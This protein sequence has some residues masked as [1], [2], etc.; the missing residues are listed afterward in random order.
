MRN[1]F[2]YF[3]GISKF[4]ISKLNPDLLISIQEVG[5]Y[6][7]TNKNDVISFKCT[8]QKS[9][10]I[11]KILDIEKC[12]YV[13]ETKGI[14][15]HIRE[16]K[17]HIGI[18]LGIVL[19]LIVDMLFSGIIW[20]IEISSNETINEKEVRETLATLGV[21]EGAIKNDIDVKK[22]FIEYMLADKNVSW[23]HLNITGTTANFEVSKR[24]VSNEERFDKIDVSNIVASCDGIIERLDVYSGGREVL[25]GESVTKGQLLISSF[26]ETRQSGFLLRRA[27]GTAI[28]Y[29][30]PCFEMMVPKEIADYNVQNE[31]K[32]KSLDVLLRNISL[33]S[34]SIKPDKLYSTP[35]YKQKEVVIFNF[36]QTPFTVHEVVFKEIYGNK[37]VRSFDDCEQI[38]NL[39][40]NQ[41]IKELEKKAKIISFDTV[42]DENDEYFIFKT[43]FSCKESIGVEKRVNIGKNNVVN[44]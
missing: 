39:K 6:A 9:K 42:Y 2:D 28:A 36:L 13:C 34:V 24:A 31:V 1:I 26:F 44:T 5:I 10:E 18:L 15:T 19:V 12:E 25:N 16:L 41:M 11:K 43:S 7:L 4:K 29:T 14:L 20:K 27:K 21:Y 40:L 22:L 3:I 8:L 32:R 35:S 37:K 17:K 30:E 33:N 38:Y 23:S